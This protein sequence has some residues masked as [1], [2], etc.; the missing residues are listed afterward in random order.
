MKTKV[1][2]IGA[3]PYGISIAN[4][5]H[6]KNIP[7]AIAGKMFSLWYEHTLNTMSIR[8]DWHSSEIYEAN[9]KYSVR[10]FIYK[11]YTLAQAKKIMSHKLPVDVFRNYLRFIESDVPYKIS[12]QHVVKLSK[13][14]NVFISEL[15]NGD[16]IESEAVVLATGIEAHKYLP[17]SLQKLNTPHVIHTWD[18]HKYAD[19]KNKNV[20]II[21]A[22]QSAGEGI[23]HLYEH[24]KIIW[25]TRKPPLFFSEPLNLPTPVFKFT[26]YLSP[27][28]YYLPHWARKKFSKI[29]VISTITPDLKEKTMSDKVRR[30][31]DDVDNIG[32]EL[33]GEKIYSKKLNQEFDGVVASTGY[34]INI[35]N[36][37]ILDAPLL[38]SIEAKDNFP[39]LD[40]DFQTSVKNLFVVGALSEP[41]YGPAQKFI[42]GTR[43]AAVRIS[44]WAEKNFRQ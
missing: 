13:K 22:G 11:N 1:F 25:L 6:K 16:I 20:L 34:K 8:S 37:K 35:N 41:H 7:F 30:V 40:F 32:L 42:M 3:G 36:L 9:D 12:S 39:L 18:V 5:L 38:N 26:L 43:H 23:V 4:A 44:R 21:G 29:F 19:W 2:I 24:N 27:Y 17:E 14:D 15:Q 28:F 31:N 10:D 33:R